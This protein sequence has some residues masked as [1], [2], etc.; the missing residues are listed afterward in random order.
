MQEQAGKNTQLKELLNEKERERGQVEE[1]NEKGEERDG[2]E[3]KGYT[4]Q[5]FSSA[6][7]A[8]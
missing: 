7:L 5:H 8:A 3:E 6:C 4:G 1:G 2:M